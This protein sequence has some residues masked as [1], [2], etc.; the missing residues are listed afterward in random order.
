[1]LFATL[2]A[3]QT[4]PP[5]PPV[6]TFGTTVVDTQGLKGDLYLMSPDSEELPNFK[7]MKPVGSIWTTAL[8]VTTR[9]FT[10]GF[11]GNTGRNEWFALDYH[12][13]FWLDQTETL[14]FGLASDDGSRLYIDGRLVIDADGRHPTAG[15]TGQAELSA[16]VHSIRISY[17]QGPGYYLALVLLVARENQAW[18]VFDTRNFKPPQSLTSDAGKQNMKANVRHLKRGRCSSLID[19]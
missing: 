6:P 7:R 9:A 3:A 17:F 14:K 2:A 13:R 11:P 10:E 8:N 4:P 5:S 1:L 15:C 12:G 16:G 19:F 18:Q